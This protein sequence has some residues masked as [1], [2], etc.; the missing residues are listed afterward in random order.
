MEGLL[1]LL[2]ELEDAGVREVCRAGDTIAIC[3]F[4]HLRRFSSRAPG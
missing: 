2:I 4:S 1:E 3:Y